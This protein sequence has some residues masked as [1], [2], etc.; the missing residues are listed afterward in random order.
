M[1]KPATLTFNVIMIEDPKGG[2]TSYFKQF[3]DVISEG[4]NEDS[5]L[6]NLIKAFHDVMAYKKQLN[7]NYM[8]GKVVEKEVSFEFAQ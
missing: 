3:P 1:E 4:D 7:G 5:A 6:T 8:P 2:F